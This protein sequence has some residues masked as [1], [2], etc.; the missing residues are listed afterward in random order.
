MGHS[1]QDISR[2]D[3]SILNCGDVPP[4]CMERDMCPTIVYRIQSSS[5]LSPSAINLPKPFHCEDNSTQAGIDVKLED[6][7]PIDIFSPHSTTWQHPTSSNHDVNSNQMY[8]HKRYNH[9]TTNLLLQGSDDPLISH[10]ANNVLSNDDEHPADFAKGLITQTSDHRH[11]DEENK[12][13]DINAAKFSDHRL[14]NHK[15]T[16]KSGCSN[17]TKQQLKVKANLMSA[18]NHQKQTQT[19][20]NVSN[21]IIKPNAIIQKSLRSQR[22]NKRKMNMVKLR[23]HHQAL[24][25]EYLSHYEA[26]LGQQRSCKNQQKGNIAQQRNT[27][28]TINTTQKQTQ[29]R[30]SNENVR[31]WLQKIAEIQRTANAS[32]EKTVQNQK[33]SQNLQ[34]QLNKTKTITNKYQTTT[35]TKIMDD[36]I[37]TQLQNM[38]KLSNSVN[39]NSNTVNDVECISNL[40]NVS[41]NLQNLYTDLP[42][43]GEIT[44]D[45]CKPRR[46]RKPKK[47]DICHLIYKNYGTILPKKTKTACPLNVM[48]DY[49]GGNHSTKMYSSEQPLN[50]CLRD[51]LNDSYSISSGEEL[52]ESNSSCP[53]PVNNPL[54]SM[55]DSMLANSLKKSLNNITDIKQEHKTIALEEENNLIKPI[56]M[57]YQ[58]L[59][60]S[61]VLLK[62]TNGPFETIQKD[63]QLAL[64]I[65]I[66]NDL[67]FSQKLSKTLSNTMPT[68]ID[69]REPLSTPSSIKSEN[70]LSSTACRSH[71][72]TVSQKRKRSAIFIPPMNIEN[73]S[74]PTTEVSICKFKFTGGSKP[75]L[76]E[77]KMI[78]VDAGG[79][80]RYYSG[81]GDKASRGFEYFPRESLQYTAGLLP[82]VNCAGQKLTVDIPSA[83]TDLNNKLQKVTEPVTLSTVISD[84]PINSGDMSKISSIST[85][86]VSKNKECLNSNRENS[87]YS[88]SSA[89]TPPSSFTIQRK[90]NTIIHQQLRKTNQ[91]E[92][93]EKTFKEQG[94]L[95][96]TQQLESAEGATYCKF[97]QLKKFTRY[98]FR[99]WKDYLPDDIQH[100]ANDTALTLTQKFPPLS[101][102]HHY[103][104][105]RNE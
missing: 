8:P 18:Q 83:S 49:L 98:L 26:S 31:S 76:Q 74:N 56:T 78:S 66:P 103:E 104:S 60:D 19:S 85:Y 1:M 34:P 53:T 84:K 4:H 16:I 20:I 39:T 12:K 96:Q 6:I 46:G 29:S 17:L 90:N 14:T 30:N 35:N 94:F 72:Y 80:Y 10:G 62:N 102:D 92:K 82:G 3:F 27:S 48:V 70:S 73:T 13:T 21:A 51:Q 88:Y 77:K 97:R 93:L 59:F 41:N 67:L 40:N 81:T 11:E 52:S 38:N 89:S 64:K 36:H 37:N 91:R 25:P 61:G 23:F 9:N 7:S 100:N 5:S 75:T 50:L 28:K 44:L 47:A 54:D 24:P 105:H 68:N 65:P 33:T 32:K 99:N 101:S 22:N 63:N 86:E 71:Q 57:Y 79:N 45:N 87:S 55:R 15:K 42:Y 2:D 69:Y 58:K 43:M 95:I